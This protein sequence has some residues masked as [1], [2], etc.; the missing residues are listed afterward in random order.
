MIKRLAALFVLA[1]A[2]VSIVLVQQTLSSQ[3]TNPPEKQANGANRSFAMKAAMGGMAEVELGQLALKQASNEEVKGFAQQMVDD[4]DKANQELKQLAESKGIQ[5]PTALDESH[6]KVSERLSKLSG[7]AFDREYMSEMVKNHQKTI[8]LFERHSKS[9][10]DQEL[11]SWAERKL[12]TL[13]EH[14]QMARD[15]GAKVGAKMPAGEK[16]AKSPSKN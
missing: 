6:R 1:I 9:S 12:P 13:R 15:I 16:A 2:A 14:L 7:A 8:S 10:S 3:S 4:H 11:K 5:L